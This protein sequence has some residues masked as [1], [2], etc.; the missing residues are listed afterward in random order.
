MHQTELKNAGY[1]LFLFECLGS[2][3]TKRGYHPPLSSVKGIPRSLSSFGQENAGLR[4]V[5]RFSPL[6]GASGRVIRPPR[7][8]PHWGRTQTKRFQLQQGV[9]HDLYPCV[10]KA[11]S[12][13]LRTAACR[14]GINKSSLYWSINLTSSSGNLKLTTLISCSFFCKIRTSSVVILVS[15]LYDYYDYYSVRRGEMQRNTYFEDQFVRT[16][17]EILE[18]MQ[19]ESQRQRQITYRES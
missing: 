14:V 1:V 11:Y 8:V 19:R 4:P 16:F 2:A 13:K 18:M 6:R 7:A 17:F 5:P 9:N 12:I 3:P 15:L 10:R